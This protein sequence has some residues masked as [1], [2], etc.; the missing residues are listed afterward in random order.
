MKTRFHVLLLILLSLGVAVL[1]LDEPRF[2]DDFTYWYHAFNLHEEGME[3]WSAKS[4]HQIRWPVWGICWALQGIIGPGLISYYGAPFLYL[5]LGALAAFAVG[6]MLFKSYGLAWGCSLVFLFHPLL[7]SAVETL[8]SRPMPDL[9]EG[10]FAAGAVLCW[11]HMMQAESKGRWVLFGAAAGVICFVAEEN[12][13]TGL[14]LIPLLCCLTALFFWRRS[15]RLLVPFAIFAVLLAGQM[16]FYK[17]QFGAWD[18]FVH[19]NLEAR[20]RRGTESVAVWTLP[21]RFLDSLSKG[22]VLAPVFSA[23]AAAGIWFGWRNYGKLG[24]VVVAWF[25]L[26]YLAYA[27]APQSLV[28]YRPMLRDADRFLAALA[29]PF[30]ILVMVGIAGLIPLI[31][32]APKARRF[33]FSHAYRSRPVLVGVV[34]FL[35]LVVLSAKPI[36]D[37]EFFSLSYVNAMRAHMRALPEKTSV[38]THHHMRALAF[39]VDADAARKIVW[40]AD[41]KWILDRQEST[42]QFARASDEFWYIRKLALLRSAKAITNDEVRKQPALASY[43]DSPEREWQLVQVLARGDSPDVVMYRKRKPGM[44]APLI[45]SSNAPELSGLFPPLPYSWKRGDT[46]DTVDVRWPIPAT[47]RG[48][49]ARIEMQG[50]SDEREAF[51]VYVAFVFGKRVQQP[52]YNLKP[53]FYKDGGREF[54]ALEIPPDADAC[55]IRVKFD[56]GAKWARVD[57]VRIIAD[58]PDQSR[59]R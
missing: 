20:G 7:D 26:H 36:G 2:G 32:A 22:G 12:R 29:I 5:T 55:Q 27:C 48:K 21:F 49:L 23:L 45:L 18:H 51:T 25:I 59:G 35:V 19:V 37:R 42:E 39:M 13:L 14:F 3:A 56:K 8:L 43:F 17:A 6:R 31:A 53:Y 57:E 4:F 44:P 50:A 16:A 38:F 40:K 11:W 58:T 9:G 24:R 54:A 33:D 15:L 30:S 1:F 34:A 47:L 52:A 10:V 46:K 41:E 28:P